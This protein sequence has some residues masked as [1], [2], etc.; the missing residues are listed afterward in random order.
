MNS[1]ERAERLFTEAA[2]DGLDGPTEEQVADAIHDAEQSVY[3]DIQM[4]LIT[5]KHPEMADWLDK[6]MGRKRMDAEDGQ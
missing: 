3:Q 4:A 5:S 1:H 6:L 2:K